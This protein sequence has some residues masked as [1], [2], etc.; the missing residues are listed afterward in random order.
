MAVQ[1]EV[2]KSRLTMRYKTEVNGAPANAELPLRLMV[3][4]DFSAGSSVD[5]KV[6]LDERRHHAMDGTN[7]DSVMREM[8]IK[9]NIAVP[10]RIDPAEGEDINVALKIDSMKSLN[11][12]QIADQI[13]KLK[14]MLALKGLLEETLSNVDNRK[15]FRKLLEQ[16]LADPDSMAKVLEDLK[17]FEGLKLPSEG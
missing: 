6:D 14:A 16:L 7:T 13:P 2:P 9:L 12:D 4:G 17:G 10:N 1:D 8:G 11:P 3:A 5:A 15:D